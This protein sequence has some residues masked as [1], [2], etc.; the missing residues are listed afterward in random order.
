MVS[1]KSRNNKKRL[2]F[3]IDCSV[4][5]LF[6]ILSVIYIF[7]LF[8]TGHVYYGDD[9]PYHLNRINELVQDI[10]H[11][12]WYPFFYSFNFDKI[13]FPMGLFYPQVTLIPF[14]LFV[15][16]TGSYVKGI[17]CALG[18]LMFV[19]LGSSYIVGRKF[20]HQRVPA[21]FVAIIYSF[22]LYFS[23]NMITRADYGE[24]CAMAFLPLALYGF[25]AVLRGEWQD[26]PYLGFGLAA[27]MLSH[28][29]STYITVLFMMAVF[30]GTI[31]FLD[32]KKA[33]IIAGIKAALAFGAAAAI[34]IGPFLIQEHFQRFNQP[35]PIPLETAPT[36]DQIFTAMLHNSI[37]RVV[38]GNVYTVGFVGLVIIICGFIFYRLLNETDRFCLITGTLLVLCTS[39]IMPLELLDKTFVGVIQFAFRGLG[40]ASFLLAVVGGKLAW[41]FVKQHHVPSGRFFRPL[42]LFILV[43]APWWATIRSFRQTGQQIANNNL[44]QPQWYL[45]QYMPAKSM[46]S[47]ND[48]QNHVAI[49]NG[50]KKALDVNKNIHS[51][52]NG[53][54]YSGSV[55][56]NAHTVDLP[57]PVYQNERVRVNGKITAYHVS[58]RNTVKLTGIRMTAN[59]RIK[60]YYQPSIFDYCAM[61][62]SLITWLGG[63]SLLVIKKISWHKKNRIV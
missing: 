13:N 49:I 22:G 18:V 40:I 4:F 33:R 51:V 37:A 35:S 8:R 24:A 1:E 29:L 61:I 32:N 48:I 11:G 3:I 60:V 5:V 43:L 20:W 7:P 23:I 12:N 27:I 56:T 55:F 14:A 63:A 26:W 54:I 36:F 53:L 47:F 28:V 15:I 39:T 25:Y 57:V 46:T 10:H 42:L 62:I 9:I 38:A 30:I 52:P 50:H 41:L 2:G 17:Y 31:W 19:A 6:A 45:D 21:F 44:I 58:R 59:T 16:I 34:F